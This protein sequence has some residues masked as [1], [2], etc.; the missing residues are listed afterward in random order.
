[1]TTADCRIVLDYVTIDKLP[2][3]VLLGIFDF[4]MCRCKLDWSPSG[5]QWARLVHVCRRWRYIVL[6][7]P[8]RLD[9]EIRL[10]CMT[11][12]RGI[13]DIWP[14]FPIAIMADVYLH[15]IEENV[16]AVL[17]HKDRVSDIC[18]Y[19]DTN[20][21]W[22]RITE[23]MKHRF[24]ILTR[25]DIGSTDHTALVLPD[26]LLGGCAPRLRS[27]SLRNIEFQQFPSYFCLPPLFSS[28]FL[29]R[30]WPIASPC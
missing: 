18:I 27:L 13:L 6:S 9:L 14:A 23:A 7:A 24:P 26:S 10:T 29:P 28:G 22:K 30:R 20:I 3:E 8:L 12:T 25:L 17:E 16:M 5:A 11:P 19:S 15:E 1:M 2:D 21:A 4:Y